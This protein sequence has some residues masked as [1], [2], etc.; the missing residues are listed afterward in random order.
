MRSWSG[1]IVRAPLG[2]ATASGSWTSASASRGGLAGGLLAAERW[3]RTRLDVELDHV[4]VVGD[5]RLGRG[6]EPVGHV[7]GIDPDT[8]DAGHHVEGTVDQLDGGLGGR[9]A[10][11]ALERDDRGGHLLGVHLEPQRGLARRATSDRTQAN[12]RARRKVSSPTSS[13][14]GGRASSSTMSPISPAVVS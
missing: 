2:V 5:R 3:D 4:G 12:G 14:V 10:G 1:A 8:V 13:A 6:R 9:G 7:G 11:V